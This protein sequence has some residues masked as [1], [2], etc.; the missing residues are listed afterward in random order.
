MTLRKRLI[1]LATVSSIYLTSIAK[2]NDRPVTCEGALHACKLYV[3]TF[4]AERQAYKN[5][6]A[7]QDQKL[8][9][10][11]SKPEPVAWYWFVLGGVV[12]GI[13]LSK[14]MK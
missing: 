7:K 14:T 3:E 12:G 5:V 2:A 4:D 13:A 10:L 11:L 1:V 9:E 6:I 8:N